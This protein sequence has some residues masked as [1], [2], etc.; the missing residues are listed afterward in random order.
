MD[1]A[2]GTRNTCSQMWCCK[3]IDTEWKSLKTKQTISAWFD[4]RVLCF[5]TQIHT[6]NLQHWHE[7]SDDGRLS[8]A[9]RV[10]K[11]EQKIKLSTLYALRQRLILFSFRLRN[12]NA[13]TNTYN[14]SFSQHLVLR[15]NF[16][17]FSTETDTA[18]HVVQK[19]MSKWFAS[20]M[21]WQLLLHKIQNLSKPWK[22]TAFSIHN[23]RT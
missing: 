9:N 20:V 6:V 2:A 13:W 14:F 5:V 22:K 8:T 7:R 12:E 4:M 10:I 1:V 23:L 15:L 21:C 16:S 19:Y 17:L 18:L 11:R 3:G